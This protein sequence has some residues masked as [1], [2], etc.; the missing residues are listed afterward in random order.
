MTLVHTKF[1][2]SGKTVALR[3][4]A[5]TGGQGEISVG[6][7]SVPVQATDFGGPL[8][9][10]WHCFGLGGRKIQVKRFRENQQESKKLLS[11]P[12]SCLR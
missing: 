8:G 5:G 6:S 10:T 1:V 3:G 9:E 4:K 11:H 2:V 7:C 12:I